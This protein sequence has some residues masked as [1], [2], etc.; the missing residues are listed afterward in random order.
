MHRIYL[1]Y[2]TILIKILDMLSIGMNQFE[3]YIGKALKH[4]HINGGIDVRALYLAS[5]LCHSLHRMNVEFQSYM[6]ASRAIF[7]L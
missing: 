2:S 1:I 3:P 5:C 7:C 6:L 4:D